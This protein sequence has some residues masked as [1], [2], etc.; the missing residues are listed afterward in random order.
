MGRVAEKQGDIE[1]A[2]AAYRAALTRDD[3]RADA[4]LR[5][6]VLHDKQGKF[7]E[8]GDLYKKA[9][10]LR[11]GDADIYCDMGYSFY[12]QR[13]WA[14]SEMN[15]RQAIALKPD[16]QRAHNNLAMLL[17]RDSRLEDAMNEFRKGG[18]DP[19][20]VHLNLAFALTLDHRW[21]L[22]QDEYER[23]LALDPSSQLAKDRLAQLNAI[24][25]KLDKPRDTG[26]QDSG[27]A[28]TST[29]APPRQQSVAPQDLR[30]A[31]TSTTAPAQQ[32][33]AAPVETTPETSLASPAKA[34]RSPDVRDP[35]LVTIGA[36]VDSLRR[37]PRTRVP[38][39]RL[40]SGDALEHAWS[41]AD[42]RNDSGQGG[43]VAPTAAR[44]DLSEP[45]AVR[46]RAQP[47]RPATSS[48]VVSTV[49]PLSQ[50]PLSGMSSP[51]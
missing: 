23:V 35:E 32:R 36:N 27:L 8:S 31:T 4:H 37:L 2:M 40:P 7:R 50:I 14:E 21:Q 25:A 49:D 20:Q 17:V 9:L 28:T 42:S 11:P 1:Q 5:L 3:H 51:K 38:M 22:A 46:P 6:A 45:A 39:P 33:S 13:R 16:H 34:A 18:N 43:P 12:L 10:A 30:L 15:L 24:L 29:S 48:G 26:L 19:V 47:R 44:E 41:V